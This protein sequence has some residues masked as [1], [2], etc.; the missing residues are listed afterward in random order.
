MR[1]TFVAW[2]VLVVVPLCAFYIVKSADG[3]NLYNHNLL[4]DKSGDL[5]SCSSFFCTPELR[6]HIAGTL[7]LVVVFQI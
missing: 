4:H 3:K 5:I 2:V 6:T 7:V 1:D